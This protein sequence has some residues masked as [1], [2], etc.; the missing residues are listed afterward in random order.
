MTILLKDIHKSK[1]KALAGEDQG[2]NKMS[3]CGVFF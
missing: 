1:G 2:F 3:K